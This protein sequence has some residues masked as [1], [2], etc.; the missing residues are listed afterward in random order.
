M[1]QPKNFA[2]D[3][4]DPLAI[5]LKK[6][7]Q[8]VELFYQAEKPKKNWMLG[9]EYELFGQIDNCSRPLPYEGPVSISTLF[10]KLSEITKLKDPLTPVMEG[11]NIVA[12]V[13]SQ[14]VIALEPGGQIEIAAL[15]HH[16]L[17]DVITNFEAVV[18]IIDDEAQNQGIQ[19]FALGIHPAATR[20]EMA[21][22]KKARYAIMQS[23]MSQLSGLGLE[24]MT[25]TCAIQLNLDF[26]N[27]MDMA[28]KTK[29]AACLSP[30][31]SLLCASVAFI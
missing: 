22:V 30:F 9:V 26:A 2:V 23:Y 31:Y 28:T 14:A 11:K 16:R 29:L 5:P 15:P 21:Q 6:I 18:K 13:G 1:S 7:D 27:E 10:H 19:L 4:I 3:E 17:T 25:R 12:L 20:D 24:M 8:L